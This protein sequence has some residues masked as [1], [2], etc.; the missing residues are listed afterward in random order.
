MRYSR[1]ALAVFTLVAISSQQCL[2]Q[3]TKIG[4]RNG[5][6]PCTTDSF[7]HEAAGE[8]EHIYGDEGTTDIPPYMGFSTVH[9]INN[10]IFNIRDRGLTTGHGSY[11]PDAWGAD[12]FIAPPGEWSMAGANNGNR[13]T[14]GAGAGLNGGSTGGSGGGQQAPVTPPYPIGPDWI[15]VQN[16][17]NGQ[18][19]GW[20][21]PG[22]TFQQFFSG[23]SGHLL[24]GNEAE[25]Q[26]ILQNQLGNMTNP[27]DFLFGGG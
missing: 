26:Y 4:M 8:A 24:P 14:N 3:G 2:A 5:L 7:V 17:H 23:Q 25:G 21:A 27:N 13:Q 16:T 20:M 1:L 10:G 6:P 15:A 9:R 22:E 12:E 19:M 18:I 11:L